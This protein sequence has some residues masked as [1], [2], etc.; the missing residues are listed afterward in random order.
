[1]TDIFS[2]LEISYNHW[3]EIITILHQT[4]ALYISII[5]LFLLYSSI[6]QKL[7]KT[8]FFMPYSPKYYHYWLSIHF[9]C[10][11]DEGQALWEYRYI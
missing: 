10:H 5:L 7:Y 2:F 11:L 3:L 6:P 8:V 9:V 1:M 4:I